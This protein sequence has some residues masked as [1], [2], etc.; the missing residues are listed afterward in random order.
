LCL[1]ALV[2]GAVNSLAG[3]G[4]LLTF[5]VLI[6]A[7]SP[8]L[9]RDE[10]A[11]V[12]NATSTVALVPGSLAGAWGYRREIPAA[13]HWLLLL[14]GPSVVGGVIG[15][16]LVTRLDPKYFAEL[17]PWLLLTA[18]LVFLVDTVVGRTRTIDRLGSSPTRGL[19]AALI[20]FQLGV[21]IYGGY[22]GAGIGILMISSLAL[23]GVGDMHRMNALKTVLNAC[24][25]GVSV[26]VFVADGKVHWPFALPMTLAA[27]LGGYLGARLALRIEPRYVRW[28]VICIGFGLAALYFRR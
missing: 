10:A 9:G 26:V 16:L 12:A 3:G 28:A 24:I 14:A 18:A 6:A 1:S 13:R 20:L 21:A 23:M 25:N 11:V 15:S 5:P 7:L 4:T 17:V 8:S 22:F 2:A 19:T 27:I